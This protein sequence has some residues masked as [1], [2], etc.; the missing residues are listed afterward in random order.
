[1]IFVYINVQTRAWTELDGNNYTV[2]TNIIFKDVYFKMLARYDDNAL[3]EYD[4]L[5]I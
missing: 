2:T 3:Y 1:M 4:E 5:K